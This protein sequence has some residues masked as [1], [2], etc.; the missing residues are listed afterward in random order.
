[1]ATEVIEPGVLERK[2]LDRCPDRTADHPTN[3]LLQHGL[4]EET[5]FNNR[6]QFFILIESILLTSFGTLQRGP[7]APA[8]A[9]GAWTVG[10]LGLV[11]TAMWVYILY[12]QKVVLDL[13]RQRMLCIEGYAETRKQIEGAFD[14]LMRCRF[15]RLRPVKITDVMGKYTPPL[16]LL[17]WVAI[18][19]IWGFR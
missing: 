16:F 10:V 2:R 14:R 9:R 17:V 7:D 6:F 3:R 18:L 5:V 11:L 19:T 8:A 12:R 4:H 1:M 15:A 13:M